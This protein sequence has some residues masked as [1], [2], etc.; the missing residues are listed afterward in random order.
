MKGLMVALGVIGAA[1]LLPI[2]RGAGHTRHDEVSFPRLL[3]DSTKGMNDSPFGHP[4]VR[5]DVA[6]FEANKAWE[7][8]NGS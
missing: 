1:A 7:E 5:Y 3:I 4:H 6:K 8:R 2:W